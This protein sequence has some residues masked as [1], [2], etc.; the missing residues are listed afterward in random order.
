MNAELKTEIIALCCGYVKPQQIKSLFN[1]PYNQQTWHIKANGLERWQTQ[2]S[3]RKRDWEERFK[4]QEAYEREQ[5]IALANE[6]IRRSNE[7]D[8]SQ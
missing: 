2:Y 8:N 1:I 4:E 6:L 5:R 3:Q 7:A